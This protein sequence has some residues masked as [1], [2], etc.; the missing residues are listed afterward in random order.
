MQDRA[1]VPHTLDFSVSDHA[2]QV[3]FFDFSVLV[4]L[5]FRDGNGTFFVRKDGKI[6]GKQG[7]NGNE[8]TPRIYGFEVG[9]KRARNEPER[10]HELQDGYPPEPDFFVRSVPFSFR[11]HS[12]Q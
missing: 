5:R 7:Q 8:S 9:D 3:L 10:T 2:F 4:N 6:E 1:S 12:A 11:A